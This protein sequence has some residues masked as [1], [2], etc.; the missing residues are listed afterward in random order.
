MLLCR[1]SR[2]G[3]ARSEALALSSNFTTLQR[4][5]MPAAV[6]PALDAGQA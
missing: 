3:G 4:G 6:Y 1:H 2:K 5:W